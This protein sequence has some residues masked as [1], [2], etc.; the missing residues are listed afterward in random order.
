MDI[1]K[2]RG[3]FPQNGWFS[4]GKPYE[5]IHNLGVPLF[6]DGLKIMENPMNKWMIWGVFPYFW[7]HLNICID[8]EFG[9][10]KGTP[11]GHVSSPRN[12]VGPNKAIS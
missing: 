5:Q 12:T 11:Q 2:N 8:P 10:P 1:S 6:L 7:K 4:N 9:Q 3:V